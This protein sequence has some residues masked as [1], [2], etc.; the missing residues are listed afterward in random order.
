MPLPHSSL[1]QALLEK[2]SFTQHRKINNASYVSQLSVTITNIW[3]NLLMKIK[4]LLW[5]TS[6]D[7]PDHNQLASWPCTLGNAAHRDRI[8]WWR[9]TIHLM[10]RKRK[11]EE[12]RAPQSL[13]RHSS[14]WPEDYPLG[15]TSSRFH[16]N[17]MEPFQGTSLPHMGLWGTSLFC[18]PGFLILDSALA[19]FWTIYN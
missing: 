6:L 8:G 4:G 1:L 11:R 2:S 10:A 9:E 5:L 14:Q 13:P 15:S 16:K 18:S 3:N 17:L 12:T 19:R 7:I